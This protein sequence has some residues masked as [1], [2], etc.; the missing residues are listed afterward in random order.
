MDGAHVSNVLGWR[1]M[2]GVNMS[3]TKRGV[4]QQKKEA[5][6]KRKAAVRAMEAEKKRKAAKKTAAIKSVKKT[7]KKANNVRKKADALGVNMIK[8]F[9]W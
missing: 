4:P 6:A 3:A 2:E 7:L 5:Q 1:D 8:R 9:K